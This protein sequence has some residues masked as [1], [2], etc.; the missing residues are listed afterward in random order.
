MVCENARIYTAECDMIK[1]VAKVDVDNAVSTSAGKRHVNIVAVIG[2]PGST[3]PEVAAALLPRLPDNTQHMIAD[4]SNVSVGV[5]TLAKDVGIRIE[6]FSNK[7]SSSDNILLSLILSAE[8]TS[9]LPLFLDNCV[10]KA[11][12]GSSAAFGIKFTLSVVSNPQLISGNNVDHEIPLEEQHFSNNRY[13][14]VFCDLL[15]HCCT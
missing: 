4:C 3:T 5:N 9:D 2:L 12:Q 6:N 13:Y 11:S 8:I 14:Y 7:H 1:S 10:D 15:L